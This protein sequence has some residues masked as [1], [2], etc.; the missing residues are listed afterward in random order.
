MA[1]ISEWDPV[2][3]GN[4]HAP[5]NGWPEFMQPSAVNNC[6]RA[7]MGAVRRWYDTVTAQITGINTAVNTKVSR[8]GDTMTGDLSIDNAAGSSAIA[9]D[10]TAAGYNQIFGNTNGV[11]RWLMRLG[12]TGEI[13][14]NQGGNFELHRYADN[15]AYLG[16]PM[17]IVRQTA[18][19]NFS[20]VVS[21]AVGGTAAGHA[22]RKD[23][24]DQ[25]DSDWYNA[26]WTNITAWAAGQDQ[27]YYNAAVAYAASIHTSQQVSI[28]AKVAKGGDTMSG[29]LAVPYIRGGPGDA[30]TLKGYEG[31]TICFRWVDGVNGAANNSQLEYRIDET[32]GKIILGTRN[33]YNAGL[34]VGGGGPTNWV[35]SGTDGTTWFYC[36]VDITA[37]DERI[38]SNI[39]QSEIDAL[40]LL[41]QVQVSQ[42]DIKPEA[43]A[44]CQSV[45]KEPEERT[46][47]MRDAQPAHV[48]IGFVAQQVKDLIPEAVFC[49]HQRGLSPDG[50]L[51]DDLLTIN[52]QMFV[53]YLVRAVQQLQARVEALEGRP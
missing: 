27:Y 1:D 38:K 32:V 13:G 34:E 3:D 21:L 6:A 2:D 28:D 26:A 50:P 42:F 16:S 49:A 52:Q 41:S 25:R 47:M 24:V 8:S 10:K 39:A 18:E 37:S 14:G 43:A 45:G 7:L 30:G 31:H 11:S 33:F 20:G 12:G 23:Y 19:V 46:Q 48:G 36:H 17:S 53:P 40:G 22:T 35:Y 44:W 9:L 4:T 15:G 5:P 51:P 29:V